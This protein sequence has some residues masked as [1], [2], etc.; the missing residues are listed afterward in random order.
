MCSSD[1]SD[2]IYNNTNF[3]DTHNTIQLNYGLNLNSSEDYKY[4]QMIEDFKFMNLRNNIHNESYINKY[5]N[6]S[7]I[8]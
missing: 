2:K 7:K 4:N 3:L 1:L 5:K 8:L 6:I